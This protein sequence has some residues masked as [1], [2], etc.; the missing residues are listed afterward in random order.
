[1]VRAGV[2]LAALVLGLCIGAHA[3][4]CDEVLPE[5]GDGP[6]GECVDSGCSSTCFSGGGHGPLLGQT[7][8]FLFSRE[9]RQCSVPGLR[10]VYGDFATASL[11]RGSF[12]P[13][14]LKSV[15]RCRSEFPRLEEY[16]SKSGLVADRTDPWRAI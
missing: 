14:Q 6:G 9:P 7:S 11:L 12:H 2:W 13:A 15:N 8:V 3:W 10:V 4:D 1:M 5:T 16:I